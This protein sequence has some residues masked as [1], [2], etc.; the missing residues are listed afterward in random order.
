MRYE[1]RAWDKVH[2]VMCYV[3]KLTWTILENKEIMMNNIEELSAIRHSDGEG[4]SG[5]VGDDFIITQ[6]I[7]RKDNNNVK[8]YE[9]D[10]VQ[11][12][13]QTISQGDM[14]LIGVIQYDP[15][16]CTYM[17]D[18][19]DYGTSVSIG[20]FIELGIIVVGNLFENQEL[21]EVKQ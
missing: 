14:F 5:Y 11:V 13:E 3:E 20:Q 10:I 21:L 17:V 1:F 16:L 6:Y 9:K 8:I 7:G 2:E 18:F 12:V 19:P 15:L 4:Y